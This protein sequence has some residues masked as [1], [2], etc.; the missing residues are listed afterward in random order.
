MEEI[1]VCNAVFR[2]SISC[3]FLEIFEIEVR[4]RP[5][6]RKKAC[7]SASFFGGGGPQILDLVFKIAPISDHVAKFR[8][9][10]SRDR[11]DLAL[12]KTRKG[13]CRLQIRATL[14]KLLHGLCKSSGVVSCIASL[15]IDRLPMVSY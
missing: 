1:V 12:N 14:A 3:S 2:L 9:D 4:N 13:S 6:S 10:L 5:K 15:P 8:G 11:G 7:F